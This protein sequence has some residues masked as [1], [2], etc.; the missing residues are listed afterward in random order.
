MSVSEIAVHCGYQD[1]AAFSKTFHR[2]FGTSPMKYRET[3][4][5]KLFSAH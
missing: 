2:Q 3:V 1:G 5:A 4:R